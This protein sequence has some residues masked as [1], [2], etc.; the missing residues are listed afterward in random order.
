MTLTHRSIERPFSLP[1]LRVGACPCTGHMYERC[2]ATYRTT[3]QDLA[4]QFDKLQAARWSRTVSDASLPE[5]EFLARTRAC[6][7]KP[8]AK[9]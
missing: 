2:C 4:V 3:G 6:T 8:P 7:R 9:C 5:S 1:R